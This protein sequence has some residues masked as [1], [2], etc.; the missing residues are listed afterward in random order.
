MALEVPT[1][2]DAVPILILCAIGLLTLPTCSILNPK[3]APNKPTITTMAAVSDGIPCKDS[4]TSIAIGVVTDLG[5][6]DMITAF[7]A[8]SHL[9]VSTTE[10][11]PT[12]QPANCEISTGISCRRILLSCRYNGTPRATMAG[13]S[14]KS[15][16][17]A[18]FSYVS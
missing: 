3:I 13:L 16:I 5:A 15:I 1:A 18:L 9:A 17:E 14:Q 2:C 8:P 4:D 7:E 6:S 12:K 10:T 11:I